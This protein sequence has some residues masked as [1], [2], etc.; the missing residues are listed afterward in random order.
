MMDAALGFRVHTGWAAAVVLAGPAFAPRVVERR[1]FTL[2]DNKDHDSVFVY[3]AA[4][5]L[6]AAAAEQL[7][8]A[9]REIA[10]AHA[11][12]E[13]A[14]LLSDLK[15]SGYTVSVVGLPRGSGR[16]LPPLSDILRSHTVIHTAEGELFR[17]ALAEA[18]G[19]QGISITG[20]VSK[21]LLQHAAQVQGLPW[22]SLKT[23]LDELG[24]SVGPPWAVDQKQAA[25]AALVAGAEASRLS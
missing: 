24:R 9:A 8:S 23:R 5:A 21:E 16:P 2:V 3:H 15:A 13:L 1:R 25:L 14:Q 17:L 12:R 10:K 4:A 7:V 22:Q 6:D 19:R 20:V 18:C 11:M